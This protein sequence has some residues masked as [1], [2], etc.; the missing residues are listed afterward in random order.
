VPLIK[1]KVSMIY[2]SMGGF[3]GLLGL[4][5]AAAHVVLMQ[6]ILFYCK[7]KLLITRFFFKLFFSG[8]NRSV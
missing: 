8:V 7:G 4:F 5:G 3:F 6:L 2:T 1:P